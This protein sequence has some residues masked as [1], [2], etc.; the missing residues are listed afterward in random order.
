MKLNRFPIEISQ[1]FII[2][3]KLKTARM[4][5]EASIDLLAL[6]NRMK[7]AVASA[8]PDRVWVRAEIAGLREGPGG[9]CY[10][11]L[12]Q[13]VRGRVVAQA[14]A[15]IW[16][17]RY[18]SVS[19]Y[20]EAV[21]GSRLTAGLEVLV[22]VQLSYHEIY[23]TTLTVDEIDP[24]YTLG[25]RERQKKET[26]ARLEQEGLLDAQKRLR[27]P[28]LPYRLAVVSAEG[29]AGFG[30]FRRHLLENPYGYAY[31]VDL[32]PAVMQGAGAP[33]S[34]AE[35][36]AA[37]G[38][39]ERPYD[40]VL[41]LR[42]GGSETDLACYDDYDLSAA[43]ARCP[44]PVFTAIGHDRDSHVADRVAHTAVKTPTALAD[45]LLDCSA[46]EDQRI[47]ALE[48][49]LQTAFRGRFARLELRLQALGNLVRSAAQAR[50]T[51]A[52][53]RLDLLETKIAA[54]DP[55]GILQRG[56]SLVLD[57]RG[58]RI[59][60]AEGRRSGEKIAVL[61]P[62]GRLDCRIEAVRTDPGPGEIR[63]A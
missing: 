56:Y 61:L 55:R 54:A 58:V 9:H 12:A 5:P 39:A 37:V 63:T 57:G 17:S 19:Q 49:R 36:L 40:V 38:A 22:R 1:I 25:E 27:L 20:F 23:G 31:R 6:Q 16:R 3:A 51:V 45:L 50:L 7:A 32:F 41:L 44:V 26:L 29:A 21:T 30:D 24:A 53:A 42:G 8:F 2:F 11:E 35:A 34:I 15:A 13:S 4:T 59:R 48:V 46:A 28:D 60:R 10:L 43:I 62:D 33:A 14:R 47:S 52:A 18:P